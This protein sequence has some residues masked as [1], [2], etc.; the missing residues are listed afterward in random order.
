V[1]RYLVTLSCIVHAETDKKAL[2]K[3]TPAVEAALPVGAAGVSLKA[4][5]LADEDTE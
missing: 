1:T 4:E 3:L 5:E 2:D